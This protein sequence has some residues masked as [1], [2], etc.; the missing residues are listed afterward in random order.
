MSTEA[1]KAAM[2]IAKN[3]TDEDKS[4]LISGSLYD[5]R[6]FQVLAFHEIYNCPIEEETTPTIEHMSDERIALRLGLNVEETKELLLD[7]FGIDTEI[8][9]RVNGHPYTQLVDAVKASGKR[10]VVAASDAL[11]DI[12]YVSDGFAIEMGVDLDLVIN[13]IHASNMTKLGEDGNPIYR[14]DGKVLKGPHYVKPDIA[15]VI[16]KKD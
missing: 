11:G 12:S 7:G 16:F 13:E 5:T 2:E 14:G 10:D 4:L 15:A 6:A 3:A 8:T 1:Y 9:Y